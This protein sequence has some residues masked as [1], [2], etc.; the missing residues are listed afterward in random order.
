MTR[1]GAE[2]LRSHRWFGV[3]SLRSFRHRSRMLQMV[4]AREEFSGKPI[5]AEIYT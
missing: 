1:K 4:Y 3:S 5:I 2:D